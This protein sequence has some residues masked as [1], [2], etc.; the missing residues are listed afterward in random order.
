MTDTRATLAGA[1]R[2]Q[3][4]GFLK[5]SLEAPLLAPVRESYANGTPIPW[6]R[7]HS[8]PDYVFFNHSSHVNAGVS[9]VSC[10]GRVDQMIEVKQVEPLS[11]LWCL[12]CHRNPAA[13]IRRR[14]FA[15]NRISP[16]TDCSGCHR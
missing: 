15:A 16:P 3:M 1:R 2:L 5:R 12:E 4:V 9:C 11:M 13:R 6:V 7:V 14:E 10:H 8:L